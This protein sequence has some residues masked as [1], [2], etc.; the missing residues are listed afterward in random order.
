MAKG[1]A[2]DLYIATVIHVLRDGKNEKGEKV[3]VTETV[4]P[5]QMVSDTD[6]TDDEVK[7]LMRHKGVLRAPTFDEQQ[8]MDSREERGAAADA[9]RTA[10][11]ERTRL[12]AEQQAE[13][14]R[15]AAE[16]AAEA[17]KER[18]KLEADQAKE[19]DRVAAEAQK[20]ATKGAK[21]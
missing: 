13:K 7:D 18:Q 9:V 8:Q 4:Q 6:L 11:D 20:A 1:K 10:E 17:E 16:Q 3:K 15:L 12:A 5:G 19:R 14:D 21:K 2:G